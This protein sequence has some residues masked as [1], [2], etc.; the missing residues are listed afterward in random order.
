MQ[1]YT[2][3]EPIYSLATAYAPSAIA[4]IRLSGIDSIKL[5]SSYFSNAN[6]LLAAKSNTLVH[7]LLIDGESVVDEVVLAVYKKGH[8]YTSEEAIEINAHGSLAGIKRIF[9]LLEK[10][11]FRQALRG[12]FSFRAFMHGRI[13]LTEAEAVEELISSKSTTS[14]QRA[15]DRLEGK[16]KNILTEIEKR[17]LY[18]LASL[19]VQLDY[20]EDEILEEWEFPHEEVDDII[21][22]LNIISSTYSAN[23]VF[24][25]GAKVVLA[26][27][28]NAG[29]SSL[30]NILTK[31]ERAIVS[32][33]KGTT[34]D[35]IESYTDFDGIPVRL[36]DTAGLRDVD[37]FIEAEGIKRSQ[38][39][40]DD[41]DL[42]IYL[43]DPSD[44]DIDFPKC[45]NL[46]K[47]YTKNDIHKDLDGL[48]VSTVTG[49][50]IG[51]LVKHVASI[52]SAGSFIEEAEV[53]IDS[54]RQKEGLEE[55]VAC[56]Q[57]AIKAES[58]SVDIMA[59][60]F[61]AALGAIGKITGEVT[62]EELLDTLFS[63]FCVGK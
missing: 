42:V 61:Q 30:F 31:E 8:G 24:R 37:D 63:S 4:I 62:N 27:L 16:L 14:Q 29:K 60:Y 28:T 48:S 3:D 49:D 46:V 25:E 10:A 17:V 9:K 38:K 51:Q 59:L 44:N 6:K 54:L 5:L 33:I 20:A 55:C 21:T 39:L 58:S 7:G 47:V 23:K 26:G 19:E 34:R 41:A 1:L 11:G 50:G 18:I 53:A 36:F 12:E 56:L 40:I 22:K 52:L 15:L 13:D 43:I 45:K 57:D 32:P 2:T 35:F